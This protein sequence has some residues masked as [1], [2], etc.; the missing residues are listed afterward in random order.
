M[1]IKKD[2]GACSPHQPF[3]SLVALLLVLALSIGCASQNS[4]RVK[5]SAGSGA[6]IGAGIGLLIGVLSGDADKAVAGLA[7]GAAVGAGQGAYEGWKQE[8]DDERTRQLAEVIRE[9]KASEARQTNIDAAA[10]AREELT[11]FLGVWTMEG[12]AQEPGEDRLTVRA[13]VNG[14]VEM[15]YFVELA[16]IDMKVSGRDAKIWG[17]SLLGFDADVGYTIN[18]RFNTLPE[19][20]RLTGNFDSSTRT[21]TFTESGAR[22]VVRFENPDRFISETFVPVEGGEQKV[23]SYRFTR[24]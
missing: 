7:V 9:S 20:I 21:F 23:E 1:Q 3:R 2:L 18:T 8:Q 17:T 5:D 15:N 19:P 22:V 16:F 10:R 6:A 11:R 14:N 4:S 12:W 13:K 24:N